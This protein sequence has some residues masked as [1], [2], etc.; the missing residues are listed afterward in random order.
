MHIYICKI[1]KLRRT[2]L[3]KMWIKLVQYPWKKINLQN[4]VCERVDIWLCLKVLLRLIAYRSA[5]C[6]YGR[7]LWL[8]RYP[9]T[10]MHCVICVL[11]SAMNHHII[12]FLGPHW[13]TETNSDQGVNMLSHWLFYVECYY[14]T[15][16]YSIGGLVNTLRPRQDGRHFQGDIF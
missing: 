3:S 2:N 15:I 16:P 9:T 11:L 10:P 1:C 13:L 4:V 12:S 7:L 5:P 8:T 14:L 6:T